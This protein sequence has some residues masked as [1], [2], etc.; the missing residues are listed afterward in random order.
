MQIQPIDLTALVATVL[1]ISIVL[2]PVDRPHASLSPQAHRGGGQPRLF[3]KG[4][5]EKILPILER[6][7]ELQEQ[8]VEGLRNAVRSLSEA[9]EFERQLAVPT[10]PSERVPV[11]KDSVTSG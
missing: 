6:R 3:E 4:S 11:V 10:P 9:R 5:T 7:M 2:V 1:G 8:E